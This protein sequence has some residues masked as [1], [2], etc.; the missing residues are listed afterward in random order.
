LTMC[1]IIVPLAARML[2]WWILEVIK[3]Y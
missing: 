1:R 2:H 3:I